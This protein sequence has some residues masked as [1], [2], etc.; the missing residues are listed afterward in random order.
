MNNTLIHDWNSY[1]SNLD[2]DENLIRQQQNKESK[3]ILES[4]N[5]MKN[6]YKLLKK[7][8]NHWAIQNN[9]T[10]RLSIKELSKIFN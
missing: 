3:K 8:S 9:P 5:Q 10:V 2:Y 1:E 4:Y 7:Y 6:D